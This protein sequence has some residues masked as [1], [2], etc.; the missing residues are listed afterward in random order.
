M[1]KEIEASLFGRRKE[2]TQY[3]L[4]IVYGIVA[5]FDEIN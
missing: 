2:L 4:R 3:V 5:K 1:G